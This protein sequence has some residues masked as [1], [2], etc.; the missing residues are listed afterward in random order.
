MYGVSQ[1][2]FHVPIKILI[3]LVFIV[4]KVSPLSSEEHKLRATKF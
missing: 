2:A 4:P 3:S 1:K